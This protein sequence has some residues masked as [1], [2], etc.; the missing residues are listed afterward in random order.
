LI[1]AVPGIFC[2]TD[3]AQGS[4]A[5]AAPT[6]DDD[7]DRLLEHIK[8]K[9]TEI[10]RVPDGWPGNIELALIDTVLSIRA[11][12]GTSAETGVRGAIKRY[13]S[14]SGRVSWDDLSVLAGIEPAWLQSVLVNKQRTG[15]VTKANAIVAAAGR[16]AQAGVRHSADVDRNSAQQ[17]AAYCGTRGLGPVTWEYLLM[18]VGHDGVKPDTLLTRFVAGAI[19]RKPDDKTV[20]RLVTDAAHRLDMP[21]SALDHSVWRYMSKPRKG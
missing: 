7:C 13:K 11:V 6:A 20:I 8:L 15:R 4:E 2:P 12:Y 16:L 21:A 5:M 10:H 3:K 19:G 17:R 1:S 9:V 18:L 14:A